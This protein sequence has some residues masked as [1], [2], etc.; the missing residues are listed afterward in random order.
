M[1]RRLA[2]PILFGLAG[3]AVL[4]WLGLWQ[5]HRLD[6]KEGILAAIE[7]RI[8]AAPVA[9]PAVPDEA[10]DEYLA[11]TAAG[12]IGQPE[13]L[14]QSSLKLV[15]PGFRV[16]APFETAGR[17]I[18]VD[19]GFVPDDQRRT[20]RP[21]VAAAL[22]GNLHWPDETDSFTP[23]PDAKTGIWFARDVPALA[24][25]LGTEPVLLVVR[26]TTEDPLAVRP[27]P[28]D[29]AGIPNDHLQYA[30]TWFLLAAVWA[31]MSLYWV[32]GLSR[33]AKED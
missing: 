15:G 6:W 29:T 9:L 27:L 18:L 7:A 21:P 13:I 16:I 28:V 33:R 23:A 24:Q 20:P 4:I 12:E 22:T 3:T 5:L 2:L 1:T 10:R 26:T 17:R 25:A 30:I 31:A 11:V 19:R 8:G 14:V 32:L